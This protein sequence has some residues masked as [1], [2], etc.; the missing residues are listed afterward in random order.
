MSIV[1]NLPDAAIPDGGV[2]H[3]HVK[4]AQRWLDARVPAAF[5]PV[6]VGWILA[7]LVLLSLVL[8]ALST[9][10][11]PEHGTSW[12][13]YVPAVLLVSLPAWYR[14]LPAATLLS[15]PV[16]AADAVRNLYVQGPA[17]GPGRTGGT[18]VLA[19]CA[20]AFAGSVLRLRSRRRQ[21]ELFLDAAGDTRAAIPED[22]PDGHRRRG[23][24]LLVTGAA[25]CLAAAALLAWV[26]RQD[27]AASPRDPFDG[28]GPQVLAMI[29]L[30]PGV[31]LLGRGLTARRAAR[32]LHDGP[33]P[34]LRVGVR[35]AL[36]G[37]GWLVADAGTT[38]APPL[39]GFRHRFDDGYRSRSAQTLLGGAESRLRTDHHDIDPHAEPYEALLYG[40]PC[41]GAEVLLRHA[42][43]RGDTTITDAV[44]AVPLMPFRRHRLRPWRPARTSYTL[45]RRAEE[46]KRR[47]RAAERSSGSGSSCGSSG[48]CGSSS[49][50]SSC[51]SSCGGG[52]GGGD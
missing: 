40:V 44:L 1:K 37:P 26:L 30:A 18:L 35:R 25:L 51:G 42:V 15:T 19:L 41:E 47:Q 32:K 46:E 50:S 16:I 7:P 11:T 43:Y 17:D 8:L 31:P 34:V 45:K 10:D 39:I 29:L 36:L 9:S 33:Q 13:G 3:W 23:R 48:G 5:A 20:W 14:F 6:T 49:C 12:A 28:T 2:P 27:L 21:R 22:L 4:D 52:C 38:T 24:A